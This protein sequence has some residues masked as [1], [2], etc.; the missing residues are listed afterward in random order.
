MQQNS[1]HEP[2]PSEMPLVR[3]LWVRRGQLV[4]EVIS[5]VR[6]MRGSGN[7]IRRPGDGVVG[8]AVSDELPG[9]AQGTPAGSGGEVRHA[10]LAPGSEEAPPD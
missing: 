5:P 9:A 1:V 6:W 2:C 3:F 8:E 10:F 4:L 7:K